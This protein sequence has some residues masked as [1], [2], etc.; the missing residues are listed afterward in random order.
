M[1]RKQITQKIKTKPM[2]TNYTNI[3]HFKFNSVN[4]STITKTVEED[5]NPIDVD[6]DLIS[7]LVMEDKN[8]GIELILDRNYFINS[9]IPFFSELSEKEKET[10]KTWLSEA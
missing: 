5:K 10:F 3:K 1:T 2:E 9:L 6:S 4:S 8:N 7:F